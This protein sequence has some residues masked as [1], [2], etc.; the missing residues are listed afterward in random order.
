MT[1]GRGTGFGLAMVGLVFLLGACSCEERADEEPAGRARPADATTAP[2]GADY[3]G[4]AHVRV[5][6]LDGTPLAG[7]APIVTKQPNAFDAPVATGPLTAANGESYVQY[8]RK[9]YL[10][11]RGWDPE[12]KY[13][14]NNFFDLLPSREAV[15]GGLEL[16]MVEGAVLTAALVGADGVPLANA[17][18]GLM[19]LHP[20]R[21]PWWPAQSNCDAAGTVRFEA[22]PP[23]SFT[24]RIKA[25]PGG[26]VE[27]PET[28]IRPGGA[29]DL[30]VLFL[31]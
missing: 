17:N 6:K 20:N 5:A 29:V 25:E 14:P 23:G 21:G 22:V 7:I 16:V 19:M 12:L 3:W 11:L 10:Y 28:A 2:S 30:G 13:F 24:L 15:V 31:H 26:M 18:A 27:V 9:E 8:P 1:R 4:T